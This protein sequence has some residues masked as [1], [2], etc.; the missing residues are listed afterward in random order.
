MSSYL[1]SFLWSLIE[2]NMVE[3]IPTAEIVN[4]VHKIEDLIPTEP[5]PEASPSPKPEASPSSKPGLNAVCNVK[6]VILL[7]ICTVIVWESLLIILN[8]FVK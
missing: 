4:G 3:V 8:H 6:D 7:T 1:F 2:E 5:K